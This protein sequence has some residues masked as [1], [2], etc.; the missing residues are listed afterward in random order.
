MISKELEIKVRQHFFRDHWPTGTI[1]TQLGLHPDTVKRVIGL[2]NRVRPG[3]DRHAKIENY[4]DFIRETLDKFP[5][6]RAT[7]LLDML[8]K[9]GYTGSV[10]PI[11]RIKKQIL[12]AS[13][14]AFLDLNFTPGEQAQVDWASFGK[15]KYGEHQRPIH[16][17]V[18][19]LSYSRR[20]FAQFFH[21]MKSARVIEGHCRAFSKFEGIP[22]SVVFDNMK[23]AV[24][25]NLGTAVRFNEDLLDMAAYYHFEPRACNPRAAWEK[26]RVERAIRY[27]RESFFAGR[28]FDSLCDLNEQ[29]RGWLS[30]ISDQRG[31]PDNREKKVIEVFAEENLASP[32]SQPFEFY[33]EKRVQVNKKSYISFDTNKYPIDPE[34]VGQYLTI[35]ACHSRIRVFHDQTLIK[36]F[37]REWGKGIKVA[38]ADHQQKIAK[39]RGI[40][41]HR[42]NR[43]SL[44]RA[45]EI[46]E[47]LLK[48]WSDLGH[49]LTASAREVV[50][51][52]QDYGVD[53][54]EAAARLAI[55]N[56]TPSACTIGYILMQE[57]GYP[58][59]KPHVEIRGDLAKIEITPPSMAD[60]DKLYEQ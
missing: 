12:P 1:S 48:T 10:Y 36:N 34:W 11:R 28:T 32:P 57:R 35:R 50:G 47:M 21:D 46:G 38:C 25:E 6:L 54:V 44:A 23:T 8:K 59:K 52:I 17:F 40:K 49:S 30:E 16:A 31:W 55:E 9:Q 22:R 39:V 26:G 27:I 4:R 15:M 42:Q 2:N 53:E 24:V 29:L 20:I 33:E 58:E 45:L 5:K 41:S 19:V 7:R 14:K 3:R 51:Y 37:D 18:M 60:Y 43:H 56:G 13:K